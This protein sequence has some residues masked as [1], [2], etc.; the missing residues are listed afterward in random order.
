MRLCNQ[1]GGLES[2][3]VISLPLLL[4]NGTFPLLQRQENQDRVS[5]VNCDQSIT[6]V[7]VNSS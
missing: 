2:G 1:S 7:S 6:L 4:A 5:S 3:E